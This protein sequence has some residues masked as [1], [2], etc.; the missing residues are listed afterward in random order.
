MTDRYDSK[1]IEVML[2]TKRVL[3]RCWA[4]IPGGGLIAT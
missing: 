4:G 1:F 3:N 2:Q